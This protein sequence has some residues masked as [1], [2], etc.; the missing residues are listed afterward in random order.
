LAVAGW[1]TGWVSK[2]LENRRH[3]FIPALATGV[4]INTALFV[5]AVPALGWSASIAFLPFLLAAALLN[6]L[7]AGFVYVG[8]RAR[9]SS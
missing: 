4:G 5:I 3:S 6:A 7:L 2:I 8:I 1:A 9:K